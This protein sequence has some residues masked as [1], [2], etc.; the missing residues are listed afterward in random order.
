[1]VLVDAKGKPVSILIA[2]AS[3]HEVKLVEQTIAQR[4]S[5]EKPRRITG[6]RAYDSDSL[7]ERLKK[8]GIELNAPHKRNR[9][10]PKTQDGRK[11][12][13]YAK[14]WKMERFFAWLFNFRRC[15][16]RYEYKA[17]NFS[18]FLLLASTIILLR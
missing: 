16:T 13:A 3:V 6:D 8:K 7:D 11:L 14:R 10:K 17:E 4:V 15:V 2:S 12:R 5:K 1:M 9:R 18:A